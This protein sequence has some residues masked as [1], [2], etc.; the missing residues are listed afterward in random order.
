[1]WVI[2]FNLKINWARIFA[3]FSGVLRIRSENEV[4]NR[5]L[6]VQIFSSIYIWIY[7]SRH[8][9]M[10]SIICL[11]TS[12]FHSSPH[13]NEFKQHVP[14]LITQAS[15]FKIS[16]HFS[17]FLHI[18]KVYSTSSLFVYYD[19]W[20]C[21]LSNIGR[22]SV[23]LCV[24]LCLPVCISCELCCAGCV[25]MV[26]YSTISAQNFVNF[27]LQL[28]LIRRSLPRVT[29]PNMYGLCRCVCSQRVPI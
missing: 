27:R 19:P 25:C 10:F 4:W 6:S 28:N 8:L 17:F 21:G 20:A 15:A 1:M 24:C 22:M 26:V 18:P 9:L 12:I 11:P 29:R 23:C 16:V 5:S 3:R 2:V 7:V 13:V 14:V